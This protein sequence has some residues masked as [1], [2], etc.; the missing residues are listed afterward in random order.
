MADDDH[1]VF[2]QVD[3][4]FKAVRLQLDGLLECGDGVLR[5]AS[6]G[7]AVGNDIDQRKNLLAIDK[8]SIADCLKKVK[9]LVDSAG[10]SC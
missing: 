7:A 8:T 10:K 6:S 4:V 2:G 3:V 5:C 9:T 1:A